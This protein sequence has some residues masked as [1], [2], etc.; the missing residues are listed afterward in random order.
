MLVLYIFMWYI[1]YVMQNDIVVG[2]C[3]GENLRLRGRNEKGV[4]TN[5]PDPFVAFSF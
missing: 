3:L 2:G 4:K 1:Q 5:I